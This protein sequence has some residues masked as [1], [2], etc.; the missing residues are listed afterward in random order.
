MMLSV[1]RRIVVNS[2]YKY[3]PRLQRLLS[4]DIKTPED[5]NDKVVQSKVP[6]LVDF[7]ASWCGPCKQLAP[8]LASVVDSFEGKLNLAKV[9]VDQHE[10]LAM[11]Y[12]VTAVPA[13]FAIKNG[14]VI[15]KFTGYKDKQQVLLFAKK[16]TE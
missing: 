14:E 16:L 2:S 10:D 8:V 7:H 5:F 15:D 9:D 1:F 3:T 12:E 6:V 13:V 4:F 11:E